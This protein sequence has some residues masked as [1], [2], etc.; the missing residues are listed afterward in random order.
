MLV[1]AVCAAGVC[2]YIM[3]AGCLPFDE[4]VVG[5][6]LRKICGARYETPPW[7]STHAAT[8]LRAMLTPDPAKRCA[9]TSKAFDDAHHRY[10]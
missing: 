1:P 4:R 2:L 8:L 10:S 5:Q 7:V 3:L 6:L 9:D